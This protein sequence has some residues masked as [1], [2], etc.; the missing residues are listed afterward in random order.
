MQKKKQKNKK[1]KK[2]TQ[3]LTSINKILISDIINIF[4]KK[5]KKSR[6]P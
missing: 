4:S 3:Y 2:K 1:T 5:K 6:L